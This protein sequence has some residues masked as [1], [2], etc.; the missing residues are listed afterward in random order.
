[1][2][3]VPPDAAYSVSSANVSSRMR[4]VAARSLAAF[5][6]MAHIARHDGSDV[7][8][9]LKYSFRRSWLCQRDKA[10][11]KQSSCRGEVPQFPDY[12]K[13]E[14]PCRIEPLA[15]LVQGTF[16]GITRISGTKIHAKMLLTLRK[17]RR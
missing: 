10:S 6:K 8:T 12:R 13:K 2:N 16:S 5:V 17:G 15:H 14:I 3:K 4:K 1:M 7:S 11:E 9:I